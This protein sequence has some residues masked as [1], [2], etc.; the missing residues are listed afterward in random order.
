VPQ[1]SELTNTNLKEK[2]RLADVSKDT[3]KYNSIEDL[4][5]GRLI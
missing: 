1:F 4:S 5:M 2:K 3:S